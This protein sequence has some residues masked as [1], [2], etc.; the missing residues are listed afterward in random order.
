MYARVA[1][2]VREHAAERA[3]RA[4]AHVALLLP[5]ITAVVLAYSHRAELFGADLPVRIG[6]D[7]AGDPRLVWPWEVRSQP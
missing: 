4:R 7:R 6:C 3:R 5:L 2:Q 1:R